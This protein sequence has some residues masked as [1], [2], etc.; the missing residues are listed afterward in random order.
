ME[1]EKKKTRI[2]HEVRKIRK[3]KAVNERWNKEMEEEEESKW[4]IRENK[5]RIGVS[6]RVGNRKKNRGVNEME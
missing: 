1:R 4:E 6:E 3:E 5:K 2:R